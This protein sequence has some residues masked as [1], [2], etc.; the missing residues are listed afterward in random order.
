MYLTLHLF[1]RLH[2]RTPHVLSIGCSFRPLPSDWHYVNFSEPWD[3]HYTFAPLR[4]FLVLIRRSSMR[5]SSMPCHCL[6]LKTRSYRITAAGLVSEFQT[7]SSSITLQKWSCEVWS[8][9]IKFS[10]NRQNDVPPETPLELFGEAQKP[11][12]PLMDRPPQ[13][14]HKPT[15]PVRIEWPSSAN[16]KVCSCWLSCLCDTHLLRSV[17]KLFKLGRIDKHC[18]TWSKLKDTNSMQPLWTSEV[19]ECIG[20][21]RNSAEVQDCPKGKSSE[22]LG[23]FSI[24]VPQTRKSL[25]KGERFIRYVERT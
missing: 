11:I 10:A 6:T 12:V 25:V 13:L 16:K 17:F 2:C 7:G 22:K 23:L 21:S 1:Q 5:H 9:T 8:W 20:A 15:T 24:G 14:L 4:Q 3:E 18:W 19:T